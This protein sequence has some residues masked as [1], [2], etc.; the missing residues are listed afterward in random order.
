MSARGQTENNKYSP[1]EETFTRLTSCPSFRCYKDEPTGAGWGKKGK[2]V[3]EGTV[4]AIVRISKYAEGEN[5]LLIVKTMNMIKNF[6]DNSLLF[7]LSETI[8]DISR[9]RL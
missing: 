2:L 4:Q 6:H 7:F 8:F 3:S 9:L 5:K 1:S